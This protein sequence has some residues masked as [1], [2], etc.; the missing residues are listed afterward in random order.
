M[1]NKTLVYAKKVQ[2]NLEESYK[3]LQRL[4]SAFNELN[5]KYSMPIDTSGS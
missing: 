5:S 1:G 3:H 2:D 4:N